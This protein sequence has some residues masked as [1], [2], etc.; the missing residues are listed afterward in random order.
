MDSIIVL[1]L[2]YVINDVFQQENV[3]ILKQVSFDGFVVFVMQEMVM[4]R[5]SEKK[6]KHICIYML[7]LSKIFIRIVEKNFYYLTR[8]MIMK[9]TKI[10]IIY[11]PLKI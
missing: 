10:M 6:K 7:K 1:F 8:I 3:V 4:Q 9:L 5:I 11:R 2:H